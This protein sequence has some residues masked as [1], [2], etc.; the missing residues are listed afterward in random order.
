[1]VQHRADDLRLSIDEE[2]ADLSV[3]V[4]GKV[5]LMGLRLV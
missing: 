2:V 4:E 1:M 3:V 5:L